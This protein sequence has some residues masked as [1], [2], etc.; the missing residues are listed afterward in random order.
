MPFDSH[1]GL[2]SPGGP[3][4]RKI[5]SISA[6]KR[7]YSRGPEISSCDSCREG[8]KSCHSV[9]N[10]GVKACWE[11]STTGRKCSHAGQSWQA[12]RKQFFAFSGGEEDQGM[13]YF[14]TFRHPAY[15]SNKLNSKTLRISSPHR[16][17]NR[18]HSWDA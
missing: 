14:S 1:G 12:K 13:I 18:S 11:C 8:S 9:L 16:D 5:P 2:I 10:P 7:R 15:R 3:L 6:K 17:A 4:S